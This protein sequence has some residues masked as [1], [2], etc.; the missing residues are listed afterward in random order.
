[1]GVSLEPRVPGGAATVYLTLERLFVAVLVGLV[2][3]KLPSDTLL[4][5][6]LLGW[7]PPSKVKNRGGISYGLLLPR[8]HLY[9]STSFSLIPL[10]K[11]FLRTS[12][13]V[14]SSVLIH[15]ISICHLD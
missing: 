7:G 14:V 5:Q 15:S 8:D 2:K 11:A 4:Q 13:T 6:T 12:S 9:I 3:L 10:A 1:M